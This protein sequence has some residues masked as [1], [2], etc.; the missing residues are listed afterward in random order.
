MR[1]LRRD[2]ATRA[3]SPLLVLG[4]RFRG[5]RYARPVS[6]LIVKRFLRVLHFFPFFLHF[7]FPPHFFLSFLRLNLSRVLLRCLLAVQ[8]FLGG[9][10]DPHGSGVVHLLGDGVLG[11][12]H[13]VGNLP[14]PVQ[15]VRCVEVFFPAVIGILLDQGL[16]A[17]S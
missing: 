1:R 11:A 9:E 15:M 3:H 5:F 8:S 4:W 7:R 10:G 2:P 12:E 6:K 17:F 14:G 16:Q 13:G